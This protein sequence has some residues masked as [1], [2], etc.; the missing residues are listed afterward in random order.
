MNWDSVEMRQVENALSFYA[1]PSNW[2]EDDWGVQSVIQPPAYGRP[3]VRAKRALD[4]LRRARRA[5]VSSNEES[6]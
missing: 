3:T 2:Q 4:A 6:G 5:D 1:D